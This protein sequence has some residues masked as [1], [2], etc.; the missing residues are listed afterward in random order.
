[1]SNSKSYTEV[2][3]RID[4][5]FR[6]LIENLPHASITDLTKE[7]PWDGPEYLLENL[8]SADLSEKFDSK[9]DFGNFKGGDIILVDS[10]RNVDG[11]DIDNHEH[12][13]LYMLNSGENNIDKVTFFGFAFSSSD[14]AIA[15]SNKFKPYPPY[16]YNILITNYNSI[17]AS[18]QPA[19][20]Q[21]RV[22][23]KINGLVEFKKKDFMYSKFS[24]VGK[25]KPEF[26]T[27]IMDVQSELRKNPNQI[28]VWD[29]KTADK[30]C[31]KKTLELV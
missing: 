12:R 28:F 29:E 8:F 5:E 6:P 10:F 7:S 26:L 31:N 21:K 30:Y 19:P 20:E 27:F 14:N 22:V 3:K 17:L 13:I 24:L 11:E 1:M 16:T 23:L 25:A 9:L 18:G 2:Y 4:K 15:K